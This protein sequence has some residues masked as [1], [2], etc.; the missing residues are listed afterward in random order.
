[1]LRL[2]RGAEIGQPNDDKDVADLSDWLEKIGEFERP[3]FAQ[4][5]R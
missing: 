5:N 2:N 3:D 1:M 4:A